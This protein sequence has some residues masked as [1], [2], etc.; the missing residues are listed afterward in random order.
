[1]VFVNSSH[2]SHTTCAVSV[3]SATA[4]AKDS[5]NITPLSPDTTFSLRDHTQH[6]LSHWSKS[7][8]CFNLEADNAIIS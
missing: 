7:L 4:E 6:N 8:A 3:P 2:Q 5:T 1:M